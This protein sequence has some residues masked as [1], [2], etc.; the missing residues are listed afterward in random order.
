MTVLDE[1]ED[2]GVEVAGL[3]VVTEDGGAVGGEEIDWGW[4][5]GE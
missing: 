1:L 5:L 4:L 2:A 3:G